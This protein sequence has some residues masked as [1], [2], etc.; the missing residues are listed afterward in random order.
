[1]YSAKAN[2]TDTMNSMTPIAIIIG[3][4]HTHQTMLNILFIVAA[5]FCCYMWI[6]WR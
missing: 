3:T 2:A 5:P 4:L 6:F 1:M